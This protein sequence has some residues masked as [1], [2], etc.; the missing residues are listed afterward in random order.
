M[1]L[2]TQVGKK[3]NLLNSFTLFYF[4]VFVVYLPLVLNLGNVFGRIIEIWFDYKKIHLFKVYNSETFSILT[5]LTHHYC[6]LIL[7]R[8]HHL[9]EKSHTASSHSIPSTLAPHFHLQTRFSVLTLK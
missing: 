5:K 9:K 3:H 4:F 8:F 1:R 7:E 6:K 2:Q